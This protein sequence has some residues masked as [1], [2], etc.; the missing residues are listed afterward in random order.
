[1]VARAF[2]DAELRL[3]KGAV[4]EKRMGQA[5]RLLVAGLKVDPANAE[6]TALL[7][8]LDRQMEAER[9]EAQK[10]LARGPDGKFDPNGWLFYATWLCQWGDYE[11]AEPHFRQMLK[12]LGGTAAVW[13]QYGHEF[14]ESR[15]SLEGAEEAV[16]A[17][18]Q[19]VALDGTYAEAWNRLWQCLRNL[20]RTDEA[21]LAAAKLLEYGRAHPDAPKAEEFLRK[22]GGAP[23]GG[24]GR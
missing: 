6:C 20:G 24:D 3:A 1:V 7:G 12:Q 10:F 2:G 23:P 17:Y 11:S 9:P 19:A 4:S 5:R 18:R 16:K 8:D 21:R 15:G 14:W 13:F 22:T